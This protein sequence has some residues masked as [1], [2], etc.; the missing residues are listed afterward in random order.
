MITTTIMVMIMIMIMIMINNGNRTEWS[1]IRSVIIRV[2][3]NEYDYRPNWM[4]RSP[5]TN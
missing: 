5:V 1:L 4:T 3:N 2:I